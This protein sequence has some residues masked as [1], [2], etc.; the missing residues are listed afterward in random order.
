ATAVPAAPVTTVPA[1]HSVPVTT[2]TTPV[3]K[4]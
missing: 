3:V 2:A 1:T 4:E